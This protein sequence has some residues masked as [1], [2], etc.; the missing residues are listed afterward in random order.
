MIN[1]QLMMINW[2]IIAR[3]NLEHFFI[4]SSIHL[5]KQTPNK[6]PEQFYSKSSLKTFSPLQKS[7][8]FSFSLN[9]LMGQEFRTRE[10]LG[11]DSTNLQLDTTKQ[12]QEGGV[13]WPRGCTLEV[14]QLIGGNF[15]GKSG[16]LT[17]SCV[18]S[19]ESRR[20]T[21]PRRWKQKYLW[22]EWGGGREIKK[23]KKKKGGR[24]GW[25]E[26]KGWRKDDD[27]RRHPGVVWGAT[28]SEDG[29]SRSS[30]RRFEWCK[31]ITAGQKQQI[32]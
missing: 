15:R 20:E 10:I 22:P 1:N 14:N 28:T 30:G 6:I 4:I 27:C 9:E 21:L 8:T 16:N 11:T 32:R 19:A 5:R 2:K 13:R 29:G 18:C 24:C 12:E 3:E 17:L 23:K 25:I 31:R 26:D 7:I